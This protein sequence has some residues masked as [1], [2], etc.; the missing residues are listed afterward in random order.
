M[1]L[2]A[3]TDSIRA[4]LFD[5]D[6]TI[7]DTREFIFQA[8]EYA[9]TAHGHEIPARSTIKKLIGKPLDECY[10]ILSG[11]DKVEHLQNAHS[12]FQLSNFSLSIPYPKAFQTLKTLKDG[13]F[14]LAVVTTRGRKTASET[15]RRAGMEEL[16]D[17]II[18][19]EDAQLKPHPEPLLKALGQIDESPAGAVMIGDTYLD[20]EAGKNAGTKTIR[21]TYGFHTERLHDPEPDFFIDDIGDI[22]KIF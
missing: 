4:F 10:R 8:F 9:L 16:F 3:L 20:I 2:P 18:S 7:L 21:A 19:G 5:V 15:L 17:A 14:K 11:L 13:G 12:Q 1:K 22:L 6:G